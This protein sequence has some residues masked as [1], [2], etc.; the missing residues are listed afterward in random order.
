MVSV[1]YEGFLHDVQR[2]ENRVEI[3][4]GTAAVCTPWMFL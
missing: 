1:L 3:T 4:N 2:I